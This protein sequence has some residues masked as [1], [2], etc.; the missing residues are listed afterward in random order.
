MV[1]PFDFTWHRMRVFRGDNGVSSDSSSRE[2]HTQ[3]H[4]AP[5]FGEHKHEMALPW[6]LAATILLA[7]LLGAL[8]GGRLAKEARQ[9][10]K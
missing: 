4:A 5:V 2:T 6:V 10:H 1:H 9:D 3:P 7:A 8:L